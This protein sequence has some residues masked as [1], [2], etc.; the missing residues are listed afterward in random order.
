MSMFPKR[1]PWKQKP[2]QLPAIN[3]GHKAFAGG[4]FPRSVHVALKGKMQRVFGGNSVASGGTG[5]AVPS[6]G[7]AGMGVGVSSGTLTDTIASFDADELGDG[8]SG[9]FVL[10]VDAEASYQ[11]YLVFGTN[12]VTSCLRIG[13]G[14]GTNLRVQLSS[15]G[16]NNKLNSTIHQS[17]LGKTF[18]V[19]VSF[20][21]GAAPTVIWKCLDDGSG[22]QV[23][24]AVLTGQYWDNINT[25]T[26]GGV[27]G[28]GSTHFFS[29]FWASALPQGLLRSLVNNPYQLFQPQIRRISAAAS[30]GGA[31]SVAGSVTHQLAIS[32][33]LDYIQAP[34]IAGSISF[35]VT[36]GGT[37]LH[38]V[39][40]L[41]SGTVAGNTHLVDANGVALAL[42]TGIGYEWYDKTTDTLGDPSDTGT[43]ST[44]AN[45][46]WSI[47]LTSSLTNGQAGTLL[48]KKG[49]GT[50]AIKAFIEK[51]VGA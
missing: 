19:G 49:T 4:Y 12:E 27:S 26:W 17:P 25:L 10:R 6:F 28:S 3:N 23:T 30:A 50:G 44:D 18:I 39:I 47:S 33:T 34:S 51:T 35:D 1:I 36:V 43:F 5:A 8:L 24:N 11:N 20:G 2:E 9:V 29:A 40:K 41:I 42:E 48:L 15:G 7:R 16:S 22:G 31:N 38:T 21:T 14:G 13:D 45:G 37:L 32:A 46:E